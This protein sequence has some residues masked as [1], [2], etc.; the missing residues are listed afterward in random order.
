MGRGNKH[1]GAVGVASV[2][3][4]PLS[5]SQRTP[6]E[7]TQRARLLFKAIVLNGEHPERKNTSQGRRRYWKLDGST[8]YCY[9][10]N[11]A[12]G[13]YEPW[14]WFSICIEGE[15]AGIWACRYN[16]ASADDRSQTN[17]E[18]DVV[19]YRIDYT[20]EQAAEI[21]CLNQEMREFSY[22]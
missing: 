16:G 22:V 20:P 7:A 6:W 3:R 8:H 11:P 4:S 17:I 12:A 5:A 1:R 19:G 10:F 2:A 14:C 15:E 21:E 9:D 18:G 13:G